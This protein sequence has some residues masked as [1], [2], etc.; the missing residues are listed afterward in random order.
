LKIG[1]ARANA[2]DSV[3][4][5][6][7]LQGLHMQGAQRIGLDNATEGHYLVGLQSRHQ[8]TNAL[9]KNGMHALDARRLLRSKRSRHTRV[10]QLDLLLLVKQSALLLLLLF[11]D[12][13]RILEDFL[14]QL[15]F[16]L[17]CNS[18]FLLSEL[19]QTNDRNTQVRLFQ[20]PNIVGSIAAHQKIFALLLQVHD[21]VLLLLWRSPRKHGNVA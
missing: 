15:A 7:E 3:L 21:Y 16:L 2:E 12:F 17:L 1:V 9:T 19:F 11:E 5:V 20:S 4:P 18:Y 13:S 10:S 8:S 14:P 6:R